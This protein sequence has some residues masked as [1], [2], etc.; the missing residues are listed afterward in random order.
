MSKVSEACGC[1]PTGRY[2]P[3]I[4]HL[5]RVRAVG[6]ASD[7]DAEAPWAAQAIAFIDTETTGRD[8]EKDRVVEIGVVL[9]RDGAAYERHSWLVNPGMPIPAEATAV[10]GIKDE[11]V[12]GERTF[13]E[14]LP[15]VLVTLRGAIPAAYNATF[16]RNFLLA[17]IGRAGVSI[18]PSPPAF[19]RDVAWLDPL[20]FARELYADEQSRALGE[21][22][23]RL[24][25]ELTRAHR[26]TDDAEAAL[27]VLY[28]LGKDA[29]VP[30]GYAALVQEQRR[31]SRSQDEARRFW[32]KN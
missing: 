27:L 16:D 19:Q 29:R 23:A 24:G 25:I 20:V 2:Y 21:M 30:P 1:F 31:L 12:Q 15:E 14:L 10:H 18:E 7:L 5:V 3:G 28:A 13:A 11:D 9:G 4:A 32:R 6:V 8:P 22:A 17:E 26:A